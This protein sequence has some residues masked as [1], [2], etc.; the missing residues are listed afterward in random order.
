M[1]V[2]HHTPTKKRKEFNG[3]HSPIPEAQKKLKTFQQQ[4]RKR[5]RIDQLEK[6]QLLDLINLLIDRHPGV[7]DTVTQNIPVPTLQA[8]CAYM[9]ELEKKLQDAIPYSKLGI[10]C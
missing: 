1:Q 5:P 7:V 8:F 10:I 3:N 4:Q 9:G 2:I 6:Q